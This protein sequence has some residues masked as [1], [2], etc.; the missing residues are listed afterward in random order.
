MRTRPPEKLDAQFIGLD[1]DGILSV[2]PAL[3]LR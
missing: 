1:V 2:D 3:G